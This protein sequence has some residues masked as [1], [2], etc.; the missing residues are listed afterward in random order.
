MNF[1]NDET[2]I[3]LL[4]NTCVFGGRQCEG[5]KKP[6]K[7]Q[8]TLIWKSFSNLKLANLKIFINGRS[9]WITLFQRSHTGLLHESKE[10]WS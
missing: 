4:C 3:C 7:A 8:K 1:K 5:T 2:Q 10:I 6:E 9:F